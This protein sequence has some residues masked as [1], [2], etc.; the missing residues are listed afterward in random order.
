[1]VKDELA[2]ILN[3]E[4]VT[5]VIFSSSHQHLECS[6]FY[7]MNYHGNSC[8]GYVAK[9]NFSLS[10]SNRLFFCVFRHRN[11]DDIWVLE[12]V[13]MGWLN[14]FL[15]LAVKGFHMKMEE[16]LARLVKEGEL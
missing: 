13:M 3:E 9:K 15:F 6:C 8:Y 5:Q 11:N 1:M 2:V 12:H 16:Y 14:D 10:C 4:T 7:P